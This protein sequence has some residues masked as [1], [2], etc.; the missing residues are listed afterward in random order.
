MRFRFCYPTQELDVLLTT[1]RH[2]HATLICQLVEPFRQS[3][4]NR[5]HLL[6]TML[7]NFC[8]FALLYPLLMRHLISDNDNTRMLRSLPTLFI[9]ENWHFSLVLSSETG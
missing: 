8:S 2:M 9:P 7:C 6:Q 3:N 5:Q 1:T 4:F